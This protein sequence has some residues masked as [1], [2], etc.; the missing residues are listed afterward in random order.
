MTTAINDSPPRIGRKTSLPAWSAD[1]G[2]MYGRDAERRAVGELLRR[3][4]H[5]A[6]GVVL[7]EGE[8][9]IGKSRLLGESVSEA[10]GQGFS[11]AAGAADRLGRTI[12]FFALRTALQPLGRF[13]A[14]DHPDGLLDTPAWWIGRLRADLERR[15]AVAP[16][17]VSLDDLQWASPAMLA[18]LRSLPGEMKG[19]PIA[20]I[21]A[22]SSARH[23][24]A[25]LLFSVLERDGATRITLGPLG[26]DAVAGLLTDAFGAPPSP[27]LLA[28]GSGAAGNPLLLTELIGG[29][30][31]DDAVR[32]TGGHALL[33]SPD[34][35]QRIVGAV[36]QRLESLSGRAR[37]LL[38]IA[39]VL[40]SSFRLE[41]AADMLAQAPAALLPVVQ[42]AMGAGIVTAAD[43]AFAFRHALVR[44]A[45]AEMIPQPARKALHRQYA[46]ILLGRGGPAAL[47]AGHLLQAAHSRDP[48]SLAG[49]D[50]AAA[51]TLPSSPQTAADLAARALELTPPGDPGAL[52]RLVAA[53]E[54]L[55]AAGRVGQ[56]ARIA[57][58]AL[59]RP[60]PAVQEARLRC[61]LAWVLCTS[62]LAQDASAEA[63]LV[64]ARPQ[65]PGDLRDQAIIAQLQA[66]AG[67]PAEPQAGRL[68]G[69]VLAS[70]RDHGDQV[71]A[72]AHIT[73]AMISWDKGRISP[74]LESLGDAARSG[75]EVSADARHVQPLLA[76]AAALVDLRRIDQA[77]GILRAAGHDKLHS[78]ASEAVPPILRARIHL[79]AGRLADAAAEAEAA[80]ATAQTLAAHGYAWVARSVLGM[81]ALRRGDLAAAAQHI[82]SRPASMRQLAG[83]Y[84]RAE[85]TLAQAQITEA[86]TGPAAA[87]GLVRDICAGLP[88]HRGLLAA[89]PAAAAWLIRVSRAAG[90]EELAATVA[91]AA[92][93][94]AG[95]NPGFGT[96]ATAAAHALGL[97]HRD[98]AR[99]AQAAAQHEDPWARA[100]AAEDLGVLLASKAD[101]DQAVRRLTEALEGYG[102]TGATADM[103]RI[104][105]RL[106]ELGVSR[107]HRA[108][109]AGRPVSGWASLT[110]TECAAS[111][112]VAQ[113]LN[114]QQIANRMYISIHTVACHLRHVF[115]KLN[116]GSRVEL[117]LIVIEQGV[118]DNLVRPV[119]T[120]R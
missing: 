82:A 55:A 120:G 99:L 103:A 56:A 31:D 89:E 5:G 23:E 118:G 106:R 47:A 111:Q 88:A 60:L 90:E 26:N 105:R 58:D 59:A 83:I 104:R 49:L 85:T 15:A 115:R 98:P 69:T 96:L 112:L 63:G 45:V 81:I 102:Q 61:V 66:L 78:I 70:A 18:A 113:G 86:R 42:E 4:R 51:Q 75:T 2:V 20:W 35:P 1:G 43:D 101:N 19:H 10:A 109:S 7:V 37:H 39:A 33:I 77:D 92:E 36:H 116:I 71:N 16:V 65:L 100:S 3:A 50:Q 64:L 44:R 17:L 79:A 68:A 54:A 34:P 46:Q 93:A 57:R 12:P 24:D 84:A 38:A 110:D 8:Q 48:A 14:G 30:R 27:D 119:S 72:A 25:E 40:G 97:A 91:H 107:R 53:A 32:V 87:L 52:P 28:L 11:L 13:V 21:F 6:G 114:N 67:M 9:G 73:R 76:L 117:A 41:D 95:D 22:R 80:L 62:G 108:S 74:A 94:L 29:L